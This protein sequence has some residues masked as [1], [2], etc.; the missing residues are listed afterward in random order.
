MESAKSLLG[1]GVFAVDGAMWKFH[2]SLTR[3]FFSRDRISHFDIFDRHAD[4]A[5][6]ILNT[7]IKEGV[8]VDMQDLAGRFTLDSASEFLFGKN[9]GSLEGIIPYPWNHSAGAFMTGGR[10]PAKDPNERFI[11]AFNLAQIKT[12]ER[13]RFGVSWPLM[14]SQFWK[15][16]VKENMKD[17]RDVLDPILEEAVKRRST[18][19]GEKTDEEKDSSTLLDHLLDHTQGGSPLFHC[20]TSNVC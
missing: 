3:P 6:S 20:S 8:A 9:V 7:R 13:G 12:A 19:I 11:R 16:E 14:K 1:T 5:L 4:R 18:M 2:R 10:D 15:D 17:V